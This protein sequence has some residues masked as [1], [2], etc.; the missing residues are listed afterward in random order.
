MRPQTSDC[1]RLLLQLQELL[2]RNETRW[3]W[4]RSHSGE[5][6]GIINRIAEQCGSGTIADLVR[7]LF[8]DAG[9]VRTAAGHALQQQVSRLSDEE[10]LQ[11]D[12]DVRDLWR[13]RHGYAGFAWSNTS[14]DDVEN[15]AAD[16][17]SRST[18]LGLLSFHHNGYVRERAIKLLAGIA[19]GSEIPFLLIRLNDWV[20]P[21]ADA[22]AKALKQRLNDAH[23]PYLLRHIAL[24]LRLLQLRRRDLSEVVGLVGDLLTRVENDAAL[25]EAILSPNRELRRGVVHIGLRRG[26]EAACRTVRH[27]LGSED[28][29]VRLWCV[30]Q[31]EDRFHGDDNSLDAILERLV[32][33]RSMP[34][35]REALRT[36]AR[37]HRERERDVWQ[38]ALLDESVAIRELAQVC[39]RRLG[40]AN[41]A[42]F[43]RQALLNTPDSISALSGLCETGVADDLPVIRGYL[44]HGFANRRS[45]AL[46]GVGRIAGAAAFEEIVACLRDPSPKVTRLAVKLLRDELPT[47]DLAPLYTVVRQATWPHSRIAALRLISNAGKWRSLPWLIKA[48]DHWDQETGEEAAKLFESW[49]H[50]PHVNRVW[51]RPSAEDRREIHSALDDL[52]EPAQSLA[53]SFIERDLKRFE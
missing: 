7:C 30:K 19:D 39:L 25:A 5:I 22:A 48:S 17:I 41:L 32:T 42:E 21:V 11:L 10:L 40:V 45:A 52:P 23:L 31:L 33:D 28:P 36:V 24:V 51:T 38:S 44:S 49:F 50:H 1:E 35:R 13:G 53:R 8:S 26:G 16:P 4:Q 43:Y 14:S 15:L 12:W 2:N 18:V 34:V 6:V 37:V 47:A 29:V 27:G 3:L 9:E 20:S 46:R